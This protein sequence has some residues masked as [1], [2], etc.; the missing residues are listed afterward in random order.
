MLH[1]TQSRMVS[2][3]P[4]G[5]AA[6]RDNANRSSPSQMRIDRTQGITKFVTGV[7]A[8]VG[9]RIAVSRARCRLFESLDP[10]SVLAVD[11][12]IYDVDR[13]FLDTTGKLWH[14]QS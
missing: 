6:I 10:R 11:P 8:A 12:S 1:P 14:A 7:K 4:T 13:K 2:I 9:G 3:Q 5:R